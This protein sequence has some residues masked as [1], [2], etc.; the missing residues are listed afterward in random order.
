[1]VRNDQI[2]TRDAAIAGAKLRVVPT[3]PVPVGSRQYDL[4]D[5]GRVVADVNVAASA[6]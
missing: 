1:M 4:T 6:E 2:R 3:E 5:R